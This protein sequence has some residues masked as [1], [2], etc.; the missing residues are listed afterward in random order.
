[1]SKKVEYQKPKKIEFSNEYSF[2]G[3]MK[4]HLEMREPTI[5]DEM[6]AQEMAR[7]E[8]ELQ[9][10]M[11]ANLCDVSLDELK[12]ITSKDGQKIAEAYNS[13]LS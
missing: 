11:F 13:F 7:N 6:N 4:N 12:P 9:L 8:S 2:N 3:V 10:L 5:G 1:M